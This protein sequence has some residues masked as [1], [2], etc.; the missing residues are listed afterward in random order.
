ML[1]NALLVVDVTHPAVETSVVSDGRSLIKVMPHNFESISQF[2][3]HV[4]KVLANAIQYRRSRSEH[5]IIIDLI[6]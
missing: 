4:L 3:C 6:T 5:R 2:L 1:C